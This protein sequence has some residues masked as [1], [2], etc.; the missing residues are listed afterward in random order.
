MR[1]IPFIAA[2]LAIA[3]A[4]G[5]ALAGQAEPSASAL[6]IEFTAEGLDGDGAP[7]IREHLENAQF[8]MIGE[9]HGH[10]GAATLIAALAAETRDLGFDH[11]AIE[12][13]P[14]SG[15]W[16]RGILERG[17]VDGLARALQGRPLAIPFLNS[18]REAEAARLFSEPG[19]LW[20]VDQEFIGSPLIHFEALMSLSPS[21]P[22]FVAALLENERTAFANGNQGGV[23]FASATEDDWARLVASFGGN[24]EAL[25]RIGAM[26]RSA[27][28]YRSFFVGRGLDNNLDRVELIREYFLS[29]YLKAEQV[30]GTPPKAIMKFGA[31][32]AG[33][34]TSAMATFDLGSL[35][36]GMA[37]ANGMDALHVAYL[38]I[39]GEALAV[40]PSADGAFQTKPVSADALL[41]LL[42][43]SGVDL[44]TI[45]ASDGHFLIDLEAIKRNLGNSGL[46]ELDPM[47]RFTVLGFDYLITTSNASAATPLAPQ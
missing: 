40:F 32:H 27:A 17:G 42:D 44:A 10:A 6:E 19:K 45:K 37:A 47:T 7:I 28:I 33:R 18:R 22:E 25:Q 20:G 9:A 31:T 14:Y 16:L 34:S 24:S 3:L 43:K 26:Q 46:A 11:Y 12:V 1:K 23:F 29:A 15:E 36:E 5:N 13:G 21:D 35:I 30:N 8:V 2:S 39:G 38:P 4:S 41:A